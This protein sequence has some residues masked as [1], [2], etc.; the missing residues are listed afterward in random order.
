MIPIDTVTDHQISQMR[1]PDKRLS[2]RAVKSLEQI[3]RMGCGASFPAIFQSR[4][5]LKGFYRLVNNQKFKPEMVQSSC[6][7]SLEELAGAGMPLGDEAY[8]ILYQDTTFGKYHGRKGLE[9]GYFNDPQTDNGVLVHSGVLTTA[10]FVP[11][12]LP[13]QAFLLREAEGHGKSAARRERAF[14]EKESFKWVA[15]LEWAAQFEKRT[16]KRVLQVA[17]REGDV[18]ELMR[19]ALELKQDFVFRCQQDRCLRADFSDKK[20]KAYLEEQAPL[21]SLAL[22]LLDE[23]GKSH[24]VPFEAKAASVRF[25]DIPEQALQVL[26]LRQTK[27]YEGQKERCSWYLVTSLPI[28]NAQDVQ[29]TAGIYTHRWRTC[30]DF[31]KCLKTGCAIEERQFENAHALLNAIALLSVLAVRLLRL[32]HLAQHQP[33]LPMTAIL[34]ENQAKLAEHFCQQTLKPS[35]W[36]HCKKGTILAFVLAIAKLGGHQGVSQK[37]M[38]GWQTIW[39]GWNYFQTILNGIMLSKN[40]GFS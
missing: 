33:E 40:S 13:V 38:P 1:L 19:R 27:A 34:D 36:K 23:K 5:D 29:K 7:S 15:G 25:E 37:G 4:G 12:G 30:E 17:D 32:R 35:D 24:S 26:F 39:K 22:T 31:H 14:S 21:A 11:V 10:D 8:F 18:A 3:D 6:A 20:L 9:L 16:R 2:A 28:E